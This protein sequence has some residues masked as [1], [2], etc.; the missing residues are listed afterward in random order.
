[1]SP[2]KDITHQRIRLK[3]RTQNFKENHNAKCKDGKMN[4]FKLK[5]CPKKTSYNKEPKEKT[6][7]FKTT[8]NTK[9]KSRFK[10]R[11]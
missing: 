4:K 9:C 3:K 6:Q 1:M 8:N 11:E 5:M 2:K 10:I 7:N